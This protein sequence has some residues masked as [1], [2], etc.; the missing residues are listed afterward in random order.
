MSR[1]STGMPGERMQVGKAL[2]SAID[3]TR[4]MLFEPFDFERWLLFGIVAFLDVFLAGGGLTRSGANFS[5][6]SQGGSQFPP[7]TDQAVEWLSQ[8]AVQIILIAIPLF[9]I[10]L[11]IHIA[12]M[13]VGCRG[14]VMFIRAVSMN[15]GQ[16]GD[17]WNA[18]KRPAFSL[19]LFRLVLIG[20][21]LA[22]ILIVSAFLL[23]AIG[24]QGGIQSG[25]ALLLTLIPFGVV[26]L[27][28]V[29]GLGLV[30]LMLRSFVV[31]IM[32]ARDLPCMEAWRVFARIAGGNALPLI[33]F[34]AVKVVYSIG[35]GIATMFVGCLTCC[36]GLLPVV[37][38]TLFAPYYVFDRAFS[39]EL[40][41]MT[42]QDDGV[43]FS[44]PAT[45]EEPPL[46]HGY[47]E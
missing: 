15:G 32:W 45:D 40:L 7:N 19:F 24:I 16:L 47:G 35:F 18:V 22:F 3:R 2:Q 25:Q 37:H 17:H 29:F 5:S 38:H 30:Q 9:L 23:I 26:F 33:G 36:I 4:T 39:L 21:W 12:L 34:V 44:P 6:Q 43:L 8:H 28:A 20:V 11:A 41:A 42:G 10:G 46:L 27:I 1:E 14:Q 31:P 13:Y